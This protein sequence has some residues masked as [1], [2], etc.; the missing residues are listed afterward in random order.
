MYC[1]TLRQRV[2]QPIV[3]FSFDDF[4]HSA[5]MAG[6][7]ILEA[8]GVCGTFYL[9]GSRCGRTVDGVP[10]FLIEDLGRLTR[11]GHEL[12]CHTFGHLSV[13]GLTANSLLKEVSQNSSFLASCLPDQVLSTFAYP[14]GHLSPPRKRQLQGLFAACR[15]SRAGLNEGRIDL[16]CLR[17]VKLYDRLLD[18]KAISSLIG[19]AVSRGSWLIFY[20]HDVDSCPSPYGCTPDKLDYAVQAALATG[21]EVLPIKSAIGAIQSAERRVA[22]HASRLQKSL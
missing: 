19:R 2:R 10:Q 18:F 15:S 3:S 11:A 5:A 9:A 16:G 14:F 6:A 13:R 8:R 1:K 20:T 17:A 21:A 12:G 7:Q 4:P 22:R